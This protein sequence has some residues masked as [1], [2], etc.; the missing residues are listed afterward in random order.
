MET[1]YPAAHSMDTTWFAV[2]KDGFI[3]VMET[4]EEGALPLVCRSG[5][6]ELNDDLVEAIAK[7]EG[8]TVEVDQYDMA[9][10][11]SV[12]LYSYHGDL[13]WSDELVPAAASTSA[14]VAG[15]AGADV[16]D[17]DAETSEGA[18]PYKR[19]GVPENPLHISKLSEQLRG[20][21]KAV[22]FDNV[23]FKETKWL[24]PA[25]RVPCEMWMDGEYHCIDEQGNAVKVPKEFCPPKEFFGFG[26]AGSS[27]SSSSSSSGTSSTPKP[28]SWWKKFFG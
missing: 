6:L 19:Q 20:G 14:E 23:S 27:S 2:D 28:T 7:Q 25:L 9:L 8:L 13:D 21:I 16:G 15:G 5:D 10:P 11:E 17:E 24:Q 12:G 18:P 4:Q 22:V 3:A 26:S 1:D